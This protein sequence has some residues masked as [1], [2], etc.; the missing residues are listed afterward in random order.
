MHD[1]FREELHCLICL[2]LGSNWKLKD[3][4]QN[5][6]CS[7]ILLTLPTITQKVCSKLWKLENCPAQFRFL[8]SLGNIG[9]GLHFCLAAI[10]WNWLLAFPFQFMFPQDWSLMAFAYIMMAHLVEIYT[11]ALCIFLIHLEKCKLDWGCLE[12]WEKWELAYLLVRVK[13]FLSVIICKWP[14]SLIWVTC[15]PPIGLSVCGEKEK[16]INWDLK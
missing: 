12:F 14:V 13:L 4:W 9:T 6:A 15:L 10:I 1:L 11:F 7:C 8:A 5:P 16:N 3:Y 2:F